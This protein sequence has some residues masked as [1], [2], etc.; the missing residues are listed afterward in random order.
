VASDGV[1]H[2][3][4]IGG[5][6]EASQAYFLPI[7]RSL[8]RHEWSPRMDLPMFVLN[9]PLLKY[10]RQD[11]AGPFGEGMAHGQTH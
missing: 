6:V 8:F 1:L 9:T 5:I 3:V 11:G 2:G 4:G 10:V 7:S